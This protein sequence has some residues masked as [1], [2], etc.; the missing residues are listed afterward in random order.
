MGF[1]KTMVLDI[2]EGITTQQIG[3]LVMVTHGAPKERHT[4]LS[5][6]I[7]ALNL[8]VLL[9]PAFVQLALNV[10]AGLALI[11]ILL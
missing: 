6:R 10:R 3:S 11:I 1:T 2:H 9:R 5:I 7:P 8:K 4:A